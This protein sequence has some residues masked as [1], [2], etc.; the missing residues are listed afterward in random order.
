M[1]WCILA[2]PASVPLQAHIT[3]PSLPVARLGRSQA[4][5]AR[6]RHLDAV[7]EL[8]ATLEPTSGWIDGLQVLVSCCSSVCILAVCGCFATCPLAAGH[9]P[10][11]PGA[12]G[13]RC[14][15]VRS[16]VPARAQQRMQR[17][18]AM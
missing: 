15:S 9:P 8:E 4:L 10:A 1:G 3:D 7:T 16:R 17:A 2:Q 5:L 12:A 18:V 13:C 6:K 14:Q 11:A